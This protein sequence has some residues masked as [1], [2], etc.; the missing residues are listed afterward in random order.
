MELTDIFR[1][2]IRK[3]IVTGIL[4]SVTIMTSRAEISGLHFRNISMDSG[5]SDN[6]VLAIE[7]D[8]YGF[9]WIGTSE[10]L[11]RYDG[12]R[13]DI[14][15]NHPD[16]LSSLSSSFVNALLLDSEGK[17]LVGTEKG[18][19]I[20]DYK[21]DSFEKFKAANDSLNLLTTLR[22]RSIHEYR[23]T[24]YLGSLE[25]L[26]C[27]DRNTRHMSF[28]KLSPG[29]GNEMAN[30][31]LCMTH[32]RYG[33]L[34]LGTYDGLY[35][36]SPGDNSFERFDARRKEKGDIVNNLINALYISEKNPDLLYIGGPSGLMV[37]DVREPGQ[38]IASLRAS[39]GGVDDEI[40]TITKY[41]DD[42]IILGT[43]NGLT[44][45]NTVS[46]KYKTFYSSLY[47]ET[48]LPSNHIKTS[49]LDSENGIIW[50]GTEHGLACLDLNK[51][52]IDFTRLTTESG[53]YSTKFIA[54]DTD[55]WN[56]ELWMASRDGV[57]R[58]DK[59]GNERNY[60][61]QDGLCHRICKSLYRDSFGTLWVGTN[62]GLNW[63]DEEEERF[64]KVRTPEHGGIPLKYIYS[65]TEDS[66]QDI[67][68]NISSGLLFIS[69]ERNSDGSIRDLSF[70]SI[71]ISDII[72]SENCDIGYI[73]A[74]DRGRIWFSAT[75]DGLFRYDKR[76][77]E[78]RNFR[79]IINDDSSL[80][81]NRVY[82]IY[83]DGKDNVWTGTDLGLCCYL[84]DEEHFIRFDDIDLRQP[85]RMITSDDRGRIWLATTNKLIMYNTQTKKK[86]V[87]DLYADFGLDEIMYNSSCKTPDGKILFGGDGGIVSFIPD[88]ITIGSSAAPL[89]IRSFY[90]WNRK[91]N[92]GQ[93]FNGRT[94]LPDNI[95]ETH[96]I[97][98]E[99]NEN[100]LGIE[101]S[102]L[103]YSSTGNKYM[104]MLE[105][106]D[107]EFNIVSNPTKIASYT[108]LS[109]GKY[110]F[111]VKACNS[112]NIW[113]EDEP[114]L[115]IT[116]RQPV[117]FRWWAWCIYVLIA[118][119]TAFAALKFFRTRI[120]LS[121]ELKMEKLE[122][123]KLEEL[124]ETK[125]RFFTNVSHDF[126]TPLSLILGP[127]ETLISSVSDKDQLA[128]LHILQ[129]NAKMLSRLINHIMDIRKIETGKEKINLKRGDIVSFARK[130]FG[131][132]ELMAKARNIQYE[133]LSAVPVL[134]MDFD[135]DK[136]EKVLYNLISNAF[137][138][139]PSGGKISLGISVES[140]GGNRLA[141]FKVT[142][143]GCGIAEDEQSHIFERFWQSKNKPCDGS[144]GLGIGL[145]IVKDFVEQHG[146][147][148]YLESAP[149]L[150]STFSFTLSIASEEQPYD[151]ETAETNGIRVLVV[152][153]NNDMQNFICMILKGK[154]KTYTA[155]D[156]ADGYSKAKN[157]NP[158]IIISD[159]M[160]PEMDG[161]TLC[162]K[163]KSEMF[164]SHIPIILLT[165]KSE[166]ESREEAYKAMADGYI[167]KPFSIKTLLAKVE[168]LV[169]QRQ[170][171][172]EKY[173]IDLLSNP[174][175]VKTESENDRFLNTIVSAIEDNID[176]SEFGI[177]E[178]CE[179]TRWSHQQIYRKI[180][181][182]TGESINEFIR[183][184]RLKR[185][186]QLLS[187]KGCRISEVMYTVGFSSHSYFTK[188]FKEKFGMSPK[189]YAKTKQN[190]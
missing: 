114:F 190:Q 141:T 101:F 85:I 116:I 17:L 124:N 60:T 42:T 46:R 10:G 150:G 68:T 120:E 91:V 126:K 78:I 176:N 145:T 61:L 43:E 93:Q 14:Y 103:N 88:N 171:L 125:M 149:C 33:M 160:M 178:L 56:G 70:K 34:W 45:Y 133:F 122:R 71:S 25:G 121:N 119:G 35:R 132:F 76:T 23:G 156:G 1:K 87:C 188:C 52:K 148:V 140:S 151:F 75:M 4:M 100:S 27:L 69:P 66:D 63:Y 58:V 74:D 40:K 128:Q 37:Y 169:M 18:L 180:R 164:T 111:H 20:Y 147:R 80:V 81:S 19:N 112:D 7:K 143:T 47:D 8:R 130:T 26:I 123:M 182:L 90:L 174:S 3:I 179:I 155:N 57:R 15:R 95:I 162:R 187:E 98:L 16:D 11:N 183:T 65:I 29:K 79:T 175:E 67:V 177:Q 138:F 102:M 152:E 135:S 165:A 159:I 64:R 22:I 170:K 158:D 137:K 96:D 186:A 146:G 185:A 9:I 51:K 167:C 39:D 134:Q 24:I 110:V 31:I 173:R 12:Y 62:N 106:Y 41:D 94:I 55:V 163:L 89:V 189:E 59:Y 54:Y 104:Y 153:D 129:S 32:D 136:I 92:P 131:Q 72:Q 49:R 50:L 139:T 144:G 30:E 172:Q 13:F 184:V 97:L 166:E 83:A 36:Y 6:M 127:L 28:F 168:M 84:A 44:L 99:H 109:P 105:G 108:N 5:L 2:S 117:F 48:S 142:D 38:E 82:S 113:S 107:K 118:V 154:Y 53:P 21:T 157:I 161:Y 77:G 86:I 181:A 115:N 73:E